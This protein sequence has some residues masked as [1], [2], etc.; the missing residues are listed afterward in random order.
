MRSLYL[1]VVV[2]AIVVVVDE[3]VATVLG[4]AVGGC[5]WRCCRQQWFS[6]DVG[7]R[8]VVQK[9]RYWVDVDVVS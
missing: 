7:V 2:V 4:Y 5:G 9:I 8:L 1:V 6:C 3:C